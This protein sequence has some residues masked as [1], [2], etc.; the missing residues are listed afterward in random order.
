M[1]KKDKKT[2]AISTS[3]PGAKETDLTALEKRIGKQIPKEFRDFLRVSDG[4]IPSKT[5]IDFGAGPYQ[6]ACVTEFFSAKGAGLHSIE[7]AVQ[8]Y[9]SRLPKGCFPIAKDD[10]SNLFVLGSDKHVFFWNHELEGDSN[11]LVH[12]ANDFKS[13]LGM[14]SL[15]EPL[16]ASVATIFFTDGTRA[17]RVLPCNTYSTTRI[18]VVSVESLKSGEEIEEFGER[19]TVRQV[20]IDIEDF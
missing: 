11:A 5:E 2:Y 20:S 6:D 15:R 18:G 19:K 10:A 7:Y 12:V 4:G 3:A 14:L 8:E 1:V 16:K 17:R 13:F 9:K